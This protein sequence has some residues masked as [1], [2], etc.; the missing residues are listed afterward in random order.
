MGTTSMSGGK[1]GGQRANTTSASGRKTRSATSTTHRGSRVEPSHVTEQAR[2]Q[3]DKKS[4]AAA[5]PS[6]KSPSKPARKPSPKAAATTP[7]KKR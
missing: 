3:R 6:K 2:E 7:R 5:K 1:S 4:Q